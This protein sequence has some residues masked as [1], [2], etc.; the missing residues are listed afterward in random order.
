MIR[1][2]VGAGL[3]LA[4]TGCLD[5]PG[6]DPGSGGLPEPDYTGGPS[7][8]GLY[9]GLTSNGEDV[10]GAVLGNGDYFFLY[11][12]ESGDLFTGGIEGAFIGRLTASNSDIESSN[13]VDVNFDGAILNYDLS[14]AY[15]TGQALL[16]EVRYTT[17]DGRFV[18]FTTDYD[19]QY[20]QTVP[21]SDIAGEYTGDTVSRA[22][23]EAAAVIVEADGT[24]SGIDAMGCTLSGSITARPD[25]NL[26]DVS[27]AFESASTSSDCPED[28]AGQTHEGWAYVD[29]QEQALVLVAQRPNDR[30]V[31][32]FFIGQ[33]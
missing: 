10:V 22:R 16:G 14:G 5:G 27:F 15:T 31:A 26:F 6:T 32:T 33:P 4:L 29:N 2:L 11:S 9:K 13:D 28:H 1:T 8:A 20:D 18:Q 7:T 25:S 19:D 23:E 21:L 24:L 3:L 17:E 30:E 12:A